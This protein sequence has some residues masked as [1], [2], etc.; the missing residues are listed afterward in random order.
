MRIVAHAD[1]SEYAGRV[2]PRLRRDEALHNLPL[3]VLGQIEEGVYEEWSLLSVEDD[4]DLVGMALRTPPW[5][6]AVACFG[7]DVD[8][9]ARSVGDHL[10][11][12]APLPGE[13]TGER[14]VAAAVADRWAVAADAVASAGMA[15]RIMDCTALEPQDEVPGMPRRVHIDDLELVV[16]W[17]VSFELETGASREPREP[18]ELRSLIAMSVEKQRSPLWVW[19]HEGEVV[20]LAGIG[21]PTGSG[22]RIGPVYTPPELRGRGY[23]GALVSHLTQDAFD[24]GCDHVFL[25]TDAANPISNRLYERLGYHHIADAARYDLTPR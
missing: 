20:S 18:T 8:A 19:E 9:F 25:F 12:E 5:P 23:A 10:A 21:R 16:R 24:R 7:D 22:E 1:P 4:Q 11:R 2:R 6:W 13:L 3:G 17:L 14:G 15:M